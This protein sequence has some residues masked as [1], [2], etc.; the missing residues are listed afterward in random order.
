[1]HLEACQERT[2]ASGQVAGVQAGD[3]AGSDGAGRRGKELS[4]QATKRCPHCGIDKSVEDFA[5]R[6]PAL[7]GR[8]AGWC[9]ACMKV[10]TRACRQ[11]K[12]EQYRDANR[13]WNNR[14]SEFL[15]DYARKYYH[16]H[17]DKW[18]EYRDRRG[19]ISY[20]ALV[21]SDIDQAIAEYKQRRDHAG[22]RALKETA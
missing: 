3:G 2:E 5:L 16:A 18:D 1:M 6:G 7:P 15:R 12:I 22:L 19:D 13:A 20:I 17:R 14:N 8:R 10:H 4:E 11:R 21:C 9:K